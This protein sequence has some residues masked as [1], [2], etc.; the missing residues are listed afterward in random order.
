MQIIAIVG[1]GFCGRLALHHLIKKSAQ[2]KIIIFDKLGAKALGPAFSSFSPHYI[3]N[4]P[5][6]NMSAFPDRPQDF[7][8]FL[9]KEYPQVWQEI[10][11]KG[12]APR[13]IYGEYLQKITSE[14]LADA[15]NSGIEVEFVGEEISEV[16]IENAQKKV[17]K[18]SGE[19]LRDR[20]FIEEISTD[21][22]KEFVE[23]SSSF[24]LTTASGKSYQASEILL[25]TSFVQSELPFNF[26]TKN[27]IKKLWDNDALQFHQQKFSDEKIC[28]IGSGLTAVDL[29]VGLKKRNFAGK[30]FV[31]SRRGNF[32]QKHFAHNPIQKAFIFS[33]DAKKG[34]LFLCLKIRKFLAANQQ[35]DLRHAIDSLRPITKEL[36]QNFDAKNKKLFLRLLPYWNIFRHRAP[37]FSIEII[38]EMLAT[39]QLEVKKCG[40]KNIVL[41]NK[42]FEIEAKNEKIVCDYVVNCLGFEFNAKKY[43]FLEQMMTDNLLRSD[44]FLVSSNHQ[45]IHLLGGLNIARDFE[46]T[47]VPDLRINV[48]D[49]V[50]KI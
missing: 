1:F 21:F 6:K 39:K 11:E 24:A 19:S 10:G 44:L 15:R 23:N 28:L 36:W 5:A 33:D 47:A 9:E 20:K 14:A 48:I 2:Q 38:E 43:P 25:A 34:V 45:K 42:K 31:I 41:K 27:L 4:V 49:V 18:I 7:C 30:I 46:C 37:A 32:P 50:R 8:Q 29:I 26:S 35:Y 40:V 13:R 16:K 3:L 12:F 22:Q 17:I